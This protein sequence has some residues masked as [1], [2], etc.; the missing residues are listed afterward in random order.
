MLIPTYTPLRTDEP[1]ASEARV[2]FGGVNVFL[3][4]HSALFRHTPW[5]LDS[6]LDSPTLLDWL[7]KRSAGMDVSKLG[8]L[9]VS[10]LAGTQGTAAKGDR[11]AAALARQTTCGRTWSIYR[12]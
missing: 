5:F 10:T 12:T 9:T 11:Q 4:Q 6:L 3:Q 7:S 1:S 2:F 8:A